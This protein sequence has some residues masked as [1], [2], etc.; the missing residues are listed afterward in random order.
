VPTAIAA[1]LRQA[2]APP[3]QAALDGRLELRVHDVEPVVEV[4]EPAIE[5]NGV[6]RTVG[7]ARHPQP[8]GLGV[9]ADHLATDALG[10]DRVDGV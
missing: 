6:L 7:L 10:P 2:L 4:V 9:D 3:V 1:D 5:L 8:V